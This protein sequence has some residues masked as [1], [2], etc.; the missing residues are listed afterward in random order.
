MGLTIAVTE[1]YRGK[2]VPV[3]LTLRCDGA[4]ESLFGCPAEFRA[5]C[6][7]WFPAAISAAHRDGWVLATDGNV[8]CGACSKGRRA[9]QEE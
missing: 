6:E 1:S 7:P 3:Q 9:V 5:L 8:Y 4:A 2:P